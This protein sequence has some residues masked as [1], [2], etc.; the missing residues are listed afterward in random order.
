MNAAPCCA[1]FNVRCLETNSLLSPQTLFPILFT[2]FSVISNEIFPTDD[3]EHEWIVRA[4]R[5]AWDEVAGVDPEKFVYNQNWRDQQYQLKRSFKT[6]LLRILFVGLGYNTI[7]NDG[8]VLSFFLSAVN[9]KTFFGLYFIFSCDALFSIK[10]WCF[11]SQLSREAFYWFL[12][13]TEM[14]FCLS[15]V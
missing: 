9:D 14:H 10:N 15:E 8:F 3:S 12:C 1:S 2:H 4:C 5:K 13:W 6:L 11:C 7:G